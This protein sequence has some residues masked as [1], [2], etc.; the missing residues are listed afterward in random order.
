MLN[1]RLR[2]KADHLGGLARTGQLSLFLGSGVS[3]PVGLPD[4]N[5]LLEQLARAANIDKPCGLKPEAAASAIKS[6]LPLET[7]HEN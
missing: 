6:A 5:G 1:G 3:R 4:W 2:E 7:Y